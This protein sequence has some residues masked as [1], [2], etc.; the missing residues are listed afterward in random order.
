MK[1]KEKFRMRK[2]V[3]CLLLSGFLLFIKFSENI[4]F[5]SEEVKGI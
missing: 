4:D 3:I 1:G 2:A 5:I